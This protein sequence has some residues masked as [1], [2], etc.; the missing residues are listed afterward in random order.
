MHISMLFRKVV[1]KIWKFQRKGYSATGLLIEERIAMPSHDA[2]DEEEFSD[3]HKT[4]SD[5]QD[6]EEENSIRIQVDLT[7]SSQLYE[8]LM[9]K[10]RSS[11][12]SIEAALVAAL[13]EV[14]SI[15]CALEDFIG[16]IEVP[17]FL[18]ER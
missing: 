1:A 8:Y 13:E 12:S 2:F 4:E 6:E 18:F 11:D 16:D 3:G 7:L 10:A 17:G 5:P 14:R 15:D 9:E